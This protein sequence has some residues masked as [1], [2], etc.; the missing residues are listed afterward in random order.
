M[1]TDL[2]IDVSNRQG[3]VPVTVLHLK[4]EIDANTYGLLQSKA[5]EAYENGSRYFLL[6]LS[7][8][9]Y[10]SSAGIR[11]LHQLFTKLRADEDPDTVRKGIRDG[12]YKSAHLKLASPQPS[13]KKVLQMTGYDMVFEI[14][15]DVEKAVN[16]FQEH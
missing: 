16:S 3:K 11:A 2:E 1:T 8:V 13:V 7:S 15:D 6:D 4:G 12:T 9:H 10:I 5:D 14:F